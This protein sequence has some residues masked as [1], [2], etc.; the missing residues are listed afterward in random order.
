L[1]GHIVLSRALAEQGQ[2]PAVDIGAS[3]SRA[4][5]QVVDREH[6]ELAEKARRLLRSHA[7]VADLVAVGAYEAGG[8]TWVDAAV[9]VMPQMRRFLSQ[10]VE[11]SCDFDEAIGWLRQIVTDAERIATGR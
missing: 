6:W 10:Q 7:D 9:A 2:Y 11:Q 1:D 5:S 4:M 8:D 3:I